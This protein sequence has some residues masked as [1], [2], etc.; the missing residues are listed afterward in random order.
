MVCKYNKYVR[1]DK[2]TCM[3]VVLVELKEKRHLATE[4]LLVWKVTQERWTVR[5]YNMF[6]I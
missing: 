1:K 5:I 2:N 3:F 6:D 4:C